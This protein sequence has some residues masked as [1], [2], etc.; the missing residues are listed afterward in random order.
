VAKVSRR[1]SRR[2]KTEQKV[3]PDSADLQSVPIP[4]IKPKFIFYPFI[5]FSLYRCTVWA[6]IANPRYQVNFDTGYDIM[7][8]CAHEHFHLEELI[9]L[10][11]KFTM[12]TL[13]IEHIGIKFLPTR[14]GIIFLLDLK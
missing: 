3:V 1:I 9:R 7:S 6:R 14:I 10:R 5:L 4:I 12:T 2:A 13:K 11:E 8:V